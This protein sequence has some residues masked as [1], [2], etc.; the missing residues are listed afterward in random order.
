MDKVQLPD[1]LPKP[2]KE[3]Q[4]AV[5]W[6]GGKSTH[7]PKDDKP[8]TKTAKQAAQTVQEKGTR[9][10]EQADRRAK[11]MLSGGLLKVYQKGRHPYS[12]VAAFFYLMLF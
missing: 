8:A 10:A 1:Q 6:Q 2:G 4:A 11:T 12:W 3:K 7:R 9:R 5:A